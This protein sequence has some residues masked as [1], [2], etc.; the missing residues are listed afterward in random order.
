VRRA[1]C[2]GAR[3]PGAVSG[4]VPHAKAALAQRPASQKSLEEWALLL[5]KAVWYVWQQGEAG[6]AEQISTVSMEV[7]SEV[8]GEGSAETLSSMD[9]FGLARS[10]GGKYEEAEAMHRQKL[11]VWEKVLG[12]EQRP[13]RLIRGSHA[14]GKKKRTHKSDRRTRSSHRSKL[15]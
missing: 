12:R 15:Y 7:R 5:Y 10:L 3:E 1:A 8:L 9:M 6:E 4:T 11:V 14:E 2:R 13:E